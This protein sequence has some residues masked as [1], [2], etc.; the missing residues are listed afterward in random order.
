MSAS[1][2]RVRASTVPRLLL[3]LALLSGSVVAGPWEQAHAASPDADATEISLS[4]SAGA[5]RSLVNVSGS[6]FGRSET[7]T[8]T[9][10]ATPVGTTVTVAGGTFAGVSLEVPPTATVGDHTVTAA[11][12]TSGLSATGTFTVINPNASITL[13]PSTGGPGSADTVSGTGFLPGEGISVFFGDT[14][15]GHTDATTTGTFSLGVAIPTG[16][17]SASYSIRAE[18]GTSGLAPSAAYTL[19]NANPAISISPGA[20]PSGSTVAVTGTGFGASETV[21]TTVWGL[22]SGSGTSN[23]SGAFTFTITIP[24]GLSNATY[25]VVAVGSTSGKVGQT[26][27]LVQTTEWLQFRNLPGH[28]GV[29]STEKLLNPTNVAGLTQAWVGATG[30]PINGSPSVANG[31]VFVGSGDGKLYAFDAL[32]G[33]TRWIYT[34]GAAIESSPAI[35]NG[36]VY[37]SSDDASVYA[38]NQTTGALVWSAATPAPIVGSPAP[39]NGN[40][41]LGSTDGLVYCYNAT[42]GA[43]VWKSSGTWGAIRTTPAV[44]NGVVYVGSDQDP[45]GAVY[46]LNATTGA[47]NWT[48]HPGGLVRSSPTIVGGVMYVGADN[49]KLY[50]YNATTGAEIWETVTLEGFVRATPSVSN[51]LVYISVA[52]FDPSDGFTEAFSA[53]T[54]VQVWWHP[55]SDYATS[56]VAVANG[57]VYSASFGHTVSAYDAKS[58]IRLWNTYLPLGVNSSPTV[59]NGYMYVGDFDNNLYAFTD[60]TPPT[61][62][63]DSNP[64]AYYNSQ[65]ASFTFHASEQL[66]GGITCSVDG[67]AGS[68]CSGGTFATP[69]LAD[70]AHS[71]AITATDIFGNTGTTT[72]SW[73]TDTVV[74]VLTVSGGPN[75]YSATTSASFDLSTN[76]PTLATYQCGLDGAAL[77]TCGPNMDYEGLVDGSHAFQATTTDAAGNVSAVVTRTWIQDTVAPVASFLT[78]PPVLTNVKVA[79]FTFASNEPGSTFKCSVDGGWFN[80]CS[81]PSSTGSL[82][83]GP[84]TFDVEAIDPAGNVSPPVQWSWTLD[85]TKPSITVTSAPSGY[86]SSTSATF[87]WTATE[88]STFTCQLDAGSATSCTSPKSY[89]GLAQGAH[90]ETITATDTAGNASSALVNWTVDTVAPTVTVTGPKSP[91]NLTTATVKISSTESGGTFSC[92][93]DGAPLTCTGNTTVSGLKNGTHSFT[94]TAYDKAGNASAPKTVTWVVDTV[95]PVLTVSGVPPALTNQKSWTFTFTSNEPGSTYKCAKDAGSF[96]SCTS[97]WTWGSQ[98]DGTHTLKVY[99]TDPAKNNSATQTFSWVVDATKPVTTITSG[100]ASS[101]TSTTATFTFTATD[102]HTVTFSCSL[103]SGATTSCVSGVTYTGLALGTHHFNVFATDAAGNVGATVT[104]TWTITS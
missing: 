5:A 46:S 56:S 4:P 101:T 51:G 44:V 68:D 3:L 30:G 102:A 6:G 27:F 19:V 61:V 104:W 13:S 82:S 80:D 58:G 49:N 91:T 83:D 36:M 74:P 32:S 14:F 52:R 34:T 79:T 55:M 92:V 7:V 96:V 103:D 38:L 72:F 29:Q 11:G 86:V 70:G 84:H 54:G 89:S 53:A 12:A 99:A 62:V 77:S 40:V 100:P 76:E 63:F 21:T 23:A 9:F 39:A 90:T 93:F 43:L 97:P 20:G 25:A 87:S 15:L 94:A 1:S 10:D 73:T 60:L 69:S 66:S 88:T 59:V 47:L 28:S 26:L 48:V 8:F 50:A 41:Y 95:P 45:S 42:T 75:G 18:A 57:V 64:P 24:N 81:S 22:P 65:S 16:I 37:I 67:G 71:L 78:G 85:A 98:S 2:L 17:P 35:A 33:A 31:V